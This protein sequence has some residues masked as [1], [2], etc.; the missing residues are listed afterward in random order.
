MC[1]LTTELSDVSSTSTPAET[2]P[3]SDG[4]PQS[5]PDTTVPP[6]TYNMSEKTPE[7]SVS[8]ETTEAE[9]KAKGKRKTT[10]QSGGMYVIFRG[11]CTIDM[12]V[13]F[14]SRSSNN[15]L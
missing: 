10:A 13:R 9:L 12:Y 4:G 8:Q 11:I 6:Q 1:H 5:N 2:E 7:T 15:Q 14:S 3:S